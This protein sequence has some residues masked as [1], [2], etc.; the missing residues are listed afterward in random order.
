VA[1]AFALSHGVLDVPNDR[2]SHNT[3]TPSGGGVAIVASTIAAASVLSWRGLLDMPLYLALCGGGVAIAA[4][5][6]L[7]DRRSL[8]AGIRLAAHLGAALWALFCLG[9]LPSLCIGH[10]TVHFGWVGYVLGALGIGWTLNL[11]NFMDGIDGI[12]AAEAAFIVWGGTLLAV[13]S[14]SGT[15]ACAMG[16]AVGA[17]CCGFLRWNWPPAKIFMGDVGSGYLGYLIGVLALASAREN[18]VALLVWLILGGVFFSDATVTLVRRSLRGERVYEAHRT[19]A[20]QLLAR[21]WHSHR[22]ATGAV[23]IVNLVWLLPCAA[24]ASFYPRLAAWMVMAGLL[25]IV[26][27]ALI[28]GAGGRAPPALYD[29]KQ[30]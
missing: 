1:R 3:P 20:Y 4:V 18:S 8:P 25:P 5:G 13:A 19:H 11:F 28:A 12:A 7:D 14:G 2:S 29:A 9:G 21:R 10:W 27:L 16:L 30:A 26:L 24:V 23:V 22:S 15:G 6:F 17:A